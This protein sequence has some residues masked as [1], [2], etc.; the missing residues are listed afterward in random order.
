MHRNT[1]KK[2]RMYCLFID[3]SS[4]FDRVQHKLLWYVLMKNGI[5][6]KFLQ[7]IQSMYSQLQSCVKTNNGLSEY[8]DCIVGTKQGCMISPF[9]FILFINELITLFNNSNCQGI[10]ID[11]QVPN[12]ISLMFADDIANVTDTVGRLQKHI[13]NLQSFCSNYGMT[14]N[15]K[16]TKIVVF[17]RGGIVKQCEQWYLNRQPIQIVAYYKYLG[18]FFTSFLKWS[19]THQHQVTQAHK[20]LVLIKKFLYICTNVRIQDAFF[21][22]DRMVVPI[23]LYG[24][25]LWGYETINLIENVQSQYCKYLL[26]LSVNT[27]NV[28]ALGECGRYPLYVKYH[29]KCIRYWIKLLHMTN[30][31]YPKHA[32]DMLYNLD[33][34]GRTTWATN[35]KQLLFKYGFGFVWISQ[36]IGDINIFLS[37]FKQRLIDCSKQDWYGKIEITD[38]LYT[39]A[40]FKSLLEVEKYLNCINVNKYKVALSRFRCSNHVL[41]I[42]CGRWK[43][44]ERNERLCELCSRINIY[45]IEDEYHFLLCCH[46]YNDLRNKYIPSTVCTKEGFINLMSTKDE[47]I[48]FNLSAFIYHAMQRRESLYRYL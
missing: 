37:T 46:S 7:V 31:R 34:A 1:K 9:M 8:F 12:V 20:A 35:I 15:L 48:L 22:F 45:D 27:E 44:V 24:A 42:E 28:A 3:F 19:K 39:Y 5:T 10:Y 13:D 14:V 32:Y 4:A 25:E 38:K 21:L 26:K 47:N 30:D 2:G 16:K 23:L 29:L 6:G 41:N 18:T 40:T 43:N 36:N 33:C 17:R 11:E